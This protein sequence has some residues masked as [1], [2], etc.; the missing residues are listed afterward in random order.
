[1]FSG[2]PL[3]HAE[4]ASDAL[5]ELTRSNVKESKLDD[6][7][8]AWFRANNEKSL[9]T[10][11]QLVSRGVGFLAGCDG[12]VPGFCLHD[13]LEWMTRAGLSP[14]QAIQAA[15]LNAAKFLGR[16]GT[17]GTI[18]VSKRADLVL[19]DADPLVDIRHTRRIAAVVLRG[20]LV[21]KAEID[22]I[23]ATRRRAVTDP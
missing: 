15:T 19:L 4:H 10:I 8:L 2:E 17:Q 11:P 9:T 18:E 14:L 7:G 23:L 20:R 12:L 13:E 6:E 22:R 16:G 5:L 1:M 3:P 21:T